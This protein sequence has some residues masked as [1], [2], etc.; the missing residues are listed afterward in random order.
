MHRGEHVGG[1]IAAPVPH[2]QWDAMNV[3]Q[4]LEL[5]RRQLA[6]LQAALQVHGNGDLVLR[7]NLTIAQ[8]ADILL[9]R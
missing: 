2:V 9:G 8:G 4:K 3:D 6:E 5:I 1:G 7:K